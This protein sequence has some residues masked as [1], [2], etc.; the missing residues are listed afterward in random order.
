M[1]QNTD[2]ANDTPVSRTFLPEG[3]KG[4]YGGVRD[5]LEGD[6]PERTEDVVDRILTGLY[7]MA[8]MLMGEGE[9][10]A[11]LVERAIESA[12]VQGCKDEARAQFNSRRALCRAG[13]AFLAEQNPDCLAAPEALQPMK[14]CIEGNE[15]ESAGISREELERAIAGPQRELLRKWLESLSTPVRTIFV[16]HAIAGYTAT[17]SAFAL[18]TYGGPKA[19]AWN[20][21]ETS[22][23]FRQGLCSLAS[24]LVHASKERASGSNS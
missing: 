1:P 9:N 4:V 18:A 14:T 21:T 20:A 22:E 17:E 24:Q 11:L 12:D 19:A 2:H 8:A 23:L 13:I 5:R 6:T 10:S 15:L 7:N 16:L 3:N